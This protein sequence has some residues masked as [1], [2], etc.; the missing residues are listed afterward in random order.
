MNLAPA[1]LR[2]SGPAYDLPITVGVLLAS[3]QVAADAS[4]VAFPGEPPF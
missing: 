4:G 3:E 1:E 2:K